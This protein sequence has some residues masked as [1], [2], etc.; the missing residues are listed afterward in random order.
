MA[1]GLGEVAVLFVEALSQMAV[2]VPFLLDT[3]RGAVVGRQPHHAAGT[4]SRNTLSALFVRLQVSL[5]SLTP[6][7]RPSRVVSSA[8]SGTGLWGGCLR[9]PS[10]LAFPCGGSLAHSSRP[11]LLSK[12]SVPGA[13]TAH[14]TLVLF[15]GMCFFFFTVKGM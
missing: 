15:L 4:L 2:A 12:S 9:R 5:S 1:P 6:H 10:H 13:L 8:V 7:A 14:Q 11:Y 3:T